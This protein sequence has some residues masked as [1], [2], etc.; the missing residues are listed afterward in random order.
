MVLSRE[1]VVIAKYFKGINTFIL[2]TFCEQT[3]SQHSSSEEIST[4]RLCKL[5]GLH[6]A[7]HYIPRNRIQ[8]FLVPSPVIRQLGHMK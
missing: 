6:I 7:Y 3:S 2:T 8:G 1:Y 5:S 4:E